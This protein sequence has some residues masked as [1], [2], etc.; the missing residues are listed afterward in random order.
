MNMVYITCNASVQ[1]Q[2]Q[3]ILDNTNIREYQIV[4]QVMSKTKVSTPRFN[5]PVWP[6]YNTVFFCLINETEKVET[7]MK[8]LKEFN[9][10]A[11]NN[12]ELITVCTWPLQYYSFGENFKPE[13][14]K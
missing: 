4:D 14:K 11:F 5:N 13:E 2:I 12:T 8:K 7:L 9:Q 1:E 3:E 10:N 6:G